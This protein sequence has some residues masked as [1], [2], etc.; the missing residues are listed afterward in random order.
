MSGSRERIHRRPPA[1][2]RHTAGIAIL[3]VAV[4]SPLLAGPVIPWNTASEHVGRRITIE[5]RVVHARRA[6]SATVLEFVR[7]DPQAFTVKLIEPLF[8]REPRDP[9]A[10][11]QG[12]RVQA[13]GIVREFQGRA[14]MI[15]RDA[16]KIVIVGLEDRPPESSPR[17]PDTREPDERCAAARAEWQGLRPKLFRQRTP[18]RRRPS[19]R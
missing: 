2:W 8:R 7:D 5:G 16:D 11:Y 10:H 1:A 6:G 18:T 19:R 17:T 14:E 12:Q 4:A 3:G 13:T 15:V 9:E